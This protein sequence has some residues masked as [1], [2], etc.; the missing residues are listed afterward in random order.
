MEM[1]S[2]LVDSDWLNRPNP[3]RMYD[4]FLGGYHNLEID[5]KAAEQLITL[6]PDIVITCRANRLFLRRAVKALAKQGIDQFL[7][8]GSGIPTVGNVHEVV[9]QINPV[10]RVLYVDIDPVAVAHSRSILQGQPNT[11]VIQADFLQ[12]ESILNHPETQRLIDFDK[13]V[14]VLMVA[15]LHFV[16]DDAKTQEKLHTLL[17]V[18]APGSH[19]VVSHATMDNHPP[20]LAEQIMQIYARSTYP[21]KVRSRIQ[22]EAFFEGFELVEPGIVNPPEWRPDSLQELG[23]DNPKQ[24]GFF[25]GVARKL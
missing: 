22:I 24:M 11:L 13:P 8:I 19:I 9:Q 18:L 3:A 21:V 17:D 14:G 25:V 20:E 16:L 2:L 23:L 7:D 1:S 5:R 10:A 12:I 4:Y 15:M 6:T